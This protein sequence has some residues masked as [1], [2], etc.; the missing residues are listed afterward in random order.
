MF[1]YPQDPGMPPEDGFDGPAGPPPP[2]DGL[3]FSEDTFEG[4]IFE[5]WTLIKR[6]TKK[7]LDQAR[8][9]LGFGHRV[10]RVFEGQGRVLAMLAMRSPIAQSELAY[11][12]GV[13]PQSLG[14]ILAKLESAGLVTREVDPND[15]RARVVSIT[16]EGL[17]QAEENAKGSNS[18]DPLTLLSDKEREQFFAVTDRIITYL[19][20]YI[21]EDDEDYGPGFP[22]PRYMGRPRRFGPPGRRGRRFRQGDWE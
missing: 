20:D 11:V 17:K 13:R 21:G 9:Q 3:P 12:L 2:R 14:E 8:R 16:E 19:E 22:P 1:G 4:R 6:A 18:A 7:D 10:H 15:A 5:I